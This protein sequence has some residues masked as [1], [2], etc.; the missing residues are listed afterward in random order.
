MS[1]KKIY[2]NRPINKLGSTLLWTA[3]F[4]LLF[5]LSLDYWTWSDAVALSYGGFPSWLF[6]FVLLQILFVLAL[7][8]FA[9]FF[10]K[11]E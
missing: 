6:Y 8:L 9:R 5:V 2:T 3:I 7:G 4:G 11:K 1:Q 10:W